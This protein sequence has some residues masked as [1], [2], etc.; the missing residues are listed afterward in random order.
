MKTAKANE[1]EVIQL[2]ARNVG[3]RVTVTPE[4]ENR[5]VLRVGEAIAACQQVK[6]DEQARDRFNFLLNR[7]GKWVLDHAAEVR[8]AY[9]TTRDGSLCFLVVHSTPAYEEAFQDALAELDIELANDRDI[10]FHVD[11][12]SLPPA[13]KEAMRSF[14]SSELT[15]HFKGG[16]NK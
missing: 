13:S 16:A 11:V 2:D 6:A 14:L 12:M 8:E 3:G 10:R 7:L 5:F 1:G 4:D 15:L 9:V